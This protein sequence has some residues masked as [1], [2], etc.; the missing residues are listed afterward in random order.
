MSF[1]PRDMD[2]IALKQMAAREIALA[3]GVPPM[4]L[5]LPGDNTYS[6]YQEANRT[7]WRQTVIPLSVRVAKSLSAWLGQGLEL[8]CDLDALDA[9]APEREALWARLDGASFLTQD[10]KRAAAGY[11]PAGAVVAKFN[12]YHD[13]AGR[14]TS[15]P[16]GGGNAPEAIPVAGRP[17]GVG[18]PKPP[19]PGVPSK[20]PASRT[21]FGATPRG[22]PFTEHGRR[23]ATERGFTDDRIDVIVEN[24]AKSRVGK[25]DASGAKTWEYS[26]A[27]GN[28]VVTNE[29]G[30]ISDHVLAPA[31]RQVCRKAIG[32][33]ISHG[34]RYCR[35]RDS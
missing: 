19:P 13:P 7:F 14:F 20:P 22:R 12:P 21:D 30:G 4:L 3:L 11:G 5:G 17:R 33:S 26:D 2:F 1:S 8:R 35:R 10:E 29:G 18:P 6:N 9:L 31:R 27:P 34:S 32:A 23:Q 28:T 16:G 25:V 24:N 15:A